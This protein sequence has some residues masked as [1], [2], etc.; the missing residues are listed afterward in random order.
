MRENGPTGRG[1]M[2]VAAAAAVLA[3]AA[4]AVAQP[5]NDACPAATPVQMGSPLT[6]A[7]TG[8]TSDGIS[9]CN[10]DL[11]ADVYHLF[12]PPVAGTY[13]FTLC[14]GTEWDTVLSLHSGCPAT[15]ANQIACDDDGCRPPGSSDVGFASSLTVD[16]PAGGTY[17]VRISGY[18][19]TVDAGLYTLLVV[20]PAAPVGACCLGGTCSLQTQAVCVT[21]GAAYRGDYIG[22]QALTSSPATYAT[23]A[24][25]VSIPDN[26]PAGI[27]STITVPVSF[28]VSDVTV[29]VELTHTFA[30]DLTIT[31]SHGSQT[32]T[33]AERIG[34]GSNGDDSNFQ[35]IYGFNDGS[36]STL[37]RAAVDSAPATGSVIPVGPHRAV[38]RYANTVLLRAAFGGVGSAGTWT[39][40]VSDNAAFDVG[41][42]GGFAITL[43]RSAGDTCSITTGACCF[44]ASCLITTAGACMGVAQ[45]FI[46]PGSACNPPGNFAAPCCKGDFNHD[47]AVSVQDIFD[48][49]I[50]YFGAQPSADT[51][52]GG[53]SLQ[54]LFDFLVAYFGGCD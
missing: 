14:T 31:L 42:L 41:T 33:L 51:G 19:S 28:T 11:S 34:G 10:L 46:A 9:D 7:A 27:L 15:I 18:D 2:L 53:V 13:T 44:G 50:A 5:A 43:D 29:A 1:L 23:T 47:G 52:G 17:R 38:D 4:T 25:P 12:T 45:Q 8:A 49:L 32:V 37:W 48:Y 16:L 40:R 36:V 24:G 26:T 35:G 20:G 30:G 54:D 21:G 39:L 22:C 3:G 6:G